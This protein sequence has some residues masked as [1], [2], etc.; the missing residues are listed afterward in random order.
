MRSLALCLT[1]F[2]AVAVA[3]ADDAATAKL[4]KSQCSTCHGKDG[5]GQTTAGKAAGVKDWTDGKTLKAVTDDQF[6]DQVRKGKKGDDG[7]EKMPP[8]KKLTDD[9]VKALIAYIRSNFQK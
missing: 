6:I 2:G 8:F 4:Y 5:K 3:R 9:Q 1:L 7:K